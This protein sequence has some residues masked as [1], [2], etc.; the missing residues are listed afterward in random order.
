VTG[1]VTS[2]HLKAATLERERTRK[3]V[4]AVATFRLFSSKQTGKILSSFCDWYKL[5]KL[6]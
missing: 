1:L 4:P 2:E 5:L 6:I 3:S